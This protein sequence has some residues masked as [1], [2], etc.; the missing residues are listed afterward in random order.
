MRQIQFLLRIAKALWQSGLLRVSPQE[1]VRILRAWW[2]CGPTFAFLGAMGAIRFPH[3]VAIHD[4][5]G[6]LTFQDL[7]QRVEGWA[8]SLL[9][10]HHVGPGSQVAI[11]C[12]NHRSFVIHL[13]A[14]TRIGADVLPLGTDLPDHVRDTILE[15]QE[16]S[17]VLGE[18]DINFD[19]PQVLGRY[20]AGQL[21]TLTSGSTGISKGIR[22]RPTLTQLLPAVTGLIESLP[23]Q[24]HRPFVL[25]IPLN[26][27]YGVATLALSLALGAPLYMATRYEIGPLVNRAEDDEPPLVVTVP[28]LL[29]RW[30]RDG[31]EKG[32]PKLAAIV[33]GSAPL[34][35]SLSMGL[36]EAF[37]PVLFNLYG[38]SEAGLISLATPAALQAAPGTVGMPLPGNEF[39]IRDSSGRGLA[40]GQTGSIWVRGPLVLQAGSDGWRDTGD[41]GYLDFAGRLFVCG[42]GDSMIVSGGENVYPH[43]VE[44]ILASHPSVDQVAIV[45]VAD[46]EFSQRMLA[47]V[48]LKDDQSLKSE[49][50]RA[51]LRKRVERFKLPRSI[52]ILREIPRNRLGKVDRKALTSVLQSSD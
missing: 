28:T 26:H 29:L 50:L 15:R 17:L 27:G 8:S 16:I 38:S 6:A 32:T 44:A 21:I 40:Q 37:G 31:F 23:F 20:R 33:T 41:L 35:E 39:L 22:R 13:L 18:S 12:R 25:A 7:D 30:L 47:A 4:E 9:R 36:L 24:L 48:V 11:V 19:N 3:R 1:F 49:S 10:D 45:V 2:L 52:Q 51:W 14:L 42:R 34:S 46:Q 43:E 5:E